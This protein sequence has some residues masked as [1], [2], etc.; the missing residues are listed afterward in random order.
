[1]L[2]VNEGG[3]LRYVGNVGTGF[4]DKE[5][6]S[7]LEATRAAS[8]RT[9]RRSRSSPKMPRVRKGDVQWVEPK[10]VAEVEFAEWT[11]D[12]RLRHPSYLGLRDDKAPAEVRAKAPIAERRQRVRT[13]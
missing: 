8:P 6:A 9:R 3:E 1:M 2:A 12:G 13:S 7:C 4:N 10:L 5:I 11:H